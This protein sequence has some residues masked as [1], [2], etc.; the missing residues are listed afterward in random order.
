MAPGEVGDWRETRWDR[1]ADEGDRAHFLGDTL[2]FTDVNPDNFMIGARRTWFVDWSWPTVGAAFIDPA[3][4]VVQLF[5]AGHTAE[6]AEAWAAEC[7]GWTTA[8]PAAI[9]AFTVATVRMNRSQA[10]RFPDANWLQDMAEAARQWAFHRGVED[11][12]VILAP[13]E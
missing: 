10:E 11:K 9:D 8:N 3:C 7:K 13:S 6:R 1:F 5:A 4:R 12:T 2:L